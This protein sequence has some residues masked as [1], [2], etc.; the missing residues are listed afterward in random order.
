MEI[1]VK[2]TMWTKSAR[3][4]LKWLNEHREEYCDTCWFGV[5]RQWLLDI[6]ETA[7]IQLYLDLSTGKTIFERI[8]D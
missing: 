5:V 8:D 1:E 3:Q 7:V 4:A 6:E 2:L